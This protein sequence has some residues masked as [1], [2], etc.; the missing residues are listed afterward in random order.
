MALIKFIETIESNLDTIPTSPGQLIFCSDT[1]DIYMDDSYFSRTPMTDIIKVPTE[2]DREAIFVPLIGKIYLVEESNTL[3]TYNGLD[4]E[5]ITLNIKIGEDASSVSEL[6]PGVLEKKGKGIAP[7]TLAS[8]VYLE[9]GNNIADIINELINRQSSLAIYKNTTILSTDE[10]SVNIGIKE[11]DKNTDLLCVYLNSTYL[12]EN[13]DYIITDNNSIRKVSGMWYASQD[14]QTFN[15]V[16]FKY[17]LKNYEGIIESSSIKDNAV[18]ENK[19]SLELQQKLNSY[20]QLIADLTS[21]IEKLE[22][23]SLIE[24]NI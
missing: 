3:Y 6:T 2:L 20:Q 24:A 9:N 16:V 13:D 22:D 8:V 21:R 18:T 23:S 10:H 12:E 7:K 14:T 11:F 1:R 17:V 5:N 4:W 19:L 15:F